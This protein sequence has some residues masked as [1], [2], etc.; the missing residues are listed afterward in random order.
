MSDAKRPVGR[1]RII[2]TPEEFDERVDAYLAE[3]KEIGKQSM[4]Q[5][6]QGV[7]GLYGLSRV[8]TVPEFI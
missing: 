2:T 8:A 5:A 4:P 7:L 3:Y 6:Q 1:P